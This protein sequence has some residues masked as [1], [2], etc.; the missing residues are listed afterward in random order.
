MA[1]L[2]ITIEIDD[3]RIYEILEEQEI[4]RPSQAKVNKLKKLFEDVESDYF[5]EFEE[6]LENALK[7]I[8][9]EEWGE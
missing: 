4:K 8:A 9:E 3:E 2:K 1:E 5:S 7:D 6:V